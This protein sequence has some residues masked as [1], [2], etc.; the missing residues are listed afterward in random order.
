MKPNIKHIFV[1]LFISLFAINI[2]A[3]T[4]VGGI[5]SGNETWQ[6][7]LSPYIVEN[8]IVVRHGAKLTI[9]AGTEVRFNANRSLI[10]EGV[11]KADGNA[12]DSIVFTSNESNKKKPFW[13]NIE[14][15]E[16][17]SSSSMTYC[18]IEYSGKNSKSAINLSGANISVP[19]FHSLTAIKNRYNGIKIPGGEYDFDINIPKADIPFII[20]ES[21][22]I[23]KGYSFVVNAGAVLKL[24]ADCNITV[25]GTFLSRGNLSSENIIT[26]LADDEYGGDTD[27]NGSS[28]GSQM[29]WGGV[30]FSR[31]CSDASNIEFTTFRF[32]G[33]SSYTQNAMLYFESCSLKMEYS[34]IENAAY[35][36]I[37]CHKNSSPDLGGGKKNSK[38]HN[39]FH[40]FLSPNY[41]IINNTTADIYAQNN[42]WG[43]DDEEYISSMIYDEEDR[44]AFGKVHYEDFLLN[45]KPTIPDRPF[46]IE[47]EDGSENHSDT[48]DFFWTKP[49]FTEYFQLY[50]SEF[51]DFSEFFIMKENIADTSITLSGFDFQTRYYWKVRGVNALGFGD[52]SE[53]HSFKTMDSSKPEKIRLIAPGYGENDVYC[54][55]SFLWEESDLADIYRIEVAV[56]SLF[57]V[58]YF[59]DD[60]I[61][62]NSYK[63]AGLE[64]YST[65]FWRVSGKNRFGWGIWSDTFKFS[66]KDCPAR[67]PP[68]NWYFENRTGSNS[69]ILFRKNVDLSS[70]GFNLEKDDAIGVFYIRGREIVCGGYAFWEGDKNIVVPVWGDNPQTNQIKDGFDYGENFRF[71][72]WRGSHN[73]EVPVA[74]NYEKGSNHY[75]P[76]K[77][78]IADS[79]KDLQEFIIDIQENNWD[80]VSSPVV[81]F[82]PFLDSLFDEN[83]LIEDN[84]SIIFYPEKNIEEK[85]IWN[86]KNGYKVNSYGKDKV[87]F[88]GSTLQLSDINIDLKKNI[89]EILPVPSLDTL[90]FYDLI[91]EVPSNILLIKDIKGDLIFPDHDHY[92]I[93]H[94]I[95]GKAYKVIAKENMDFRYTAIKRSDDLLLDNDTEHFSPDYYNTG[96]NMTMVVESEDIDTDDELA[97]L[98]GDNK[99]AGVA[100]EHEGKFITTIWGDDLFTEDIID[101]CEDNEALSLLIWKKN[102]N[103]EYSFFVHELY[104]AIT[105]RKI[106]GGLKFV[107]DAIYI[108]KCSMQPSD[109]PER[110]SNV[111][112]EVS[113]NPA[114]DEFLVDLFLKES[115]PVIMNII[116]LTGEKTKIHSEFMSKGRHFINYSTVDLYCGF[117]ILEIILNNK[118]YHKK[119]IVYD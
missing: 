94:F 24:G 84:E 107:E 37:F 64:E 105:D 74:V 22:E 80:M 81:P 33:R 89:W 27:G 86:E 31:Y 109:I 110:S 17:R 36:G 75:I 26:S 25:H 102:E 48:I 93:K 50:I 70:L 73:E 6:K 76:D 116:S 8:D 10:I 35:Q 43:S 68:G 46:L 69:T 91:P 59:S 30:Y 65:Y 60:Q 90:S 97:V 88:F 51:N 62:E 41:V 14:F 78:A 20:K 99:I 44:S 67:M 103:R 11:L 12:M 104:N 58:I 15:V 52:H 95:P 85:Y 19:V 96:R 18:R 21:I 71:K 13:G 111:S 56:D 2:Y 9:E 28:S 34:T 1:I 113:P 7:S 108:A 45:C 4:R 53:I 38:G 39:S 119:L 77:L 106:I 118:T 55:M 72:I 112:I 83:I 82:Y 117:Y 100:K 54:S 92:G 29:L 61:A 63:I 57:N 98:T 79:I 87:R 40:G 115:S 114:V 3:E 23:A 47:P 16:P 32:G 5:I 49:Q 42:C 66:T 101:G